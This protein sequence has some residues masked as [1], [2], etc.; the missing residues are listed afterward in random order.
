MCA[1]VAWDKLA[2]DSGNSSGSKRDVE[3]LKVKGGN[4]YQIRPVGSAITVTKVFH[5]KDGRTHFA[6]IDHL[7]DEGEEILEKLHSEYG[8]EGTRKFI[9][10]VIDRSDG[11]LKIY[12]GP[13]TVFE[14]FAEWANEAEVEEPGGKDGID[15]IISVKGDGFDRRYTV[16]P[17]SPTPFSAEEK[18]MITEK[19]VKGDH[20]LDTLYKPHD[21]EKVEELLFGE[22]GPS[23]QTA[24]AVAAQGN[25]PLDDDKEFNF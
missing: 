6:V 17:K 12:E 20:N 11:K 25:V 4:K 5:K 13:K 23:S 7:T 10:N 18:K 1:Q 9:M 14:A 22:S 16:I 19:M 21:A 8:I 2:S 24:A 3:Y 15:F